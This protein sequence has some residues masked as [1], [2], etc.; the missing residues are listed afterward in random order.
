MVG[1]MWAPPPIYTHPPARP[2]TPPHPPTSPPARPPARPQVMSAVHD[3]LLELPECGV[4]EVRIGH[5]QLFELALQY[6]GE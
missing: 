3:V 4:L 5:R 2:P 6:V 1:E